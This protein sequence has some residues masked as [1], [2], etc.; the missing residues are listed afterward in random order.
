MSGIPATKATAMETSTT[1]EDD[2]PLDLEEKVEIPAQICIVTS[3]QKNFMISGA[4]ANKSMVLRAAFSFDTTDPI[5]VAIPS[6]LMAKIIAYLEYHVDVPTVVIPK[7]LKNNKLA[8]NGVCEYDVKFVSVTN[9]I[10][11]ELMKAANQLHIDSLLQLTCAATAVQI[12]GKTTKEL[13]EMFNITDDFVPEVK[14]PT[15]MKTD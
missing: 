13:K 10:L 15:E 2:K 8:D 14:R 5:P 11:F 4:A 3:D 12:K 7:P 1:S 6:E 9:D